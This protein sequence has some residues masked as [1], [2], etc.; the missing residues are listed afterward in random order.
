LIKN[1]DSIYRT[2]KTGI[3]TVLYN[4][5]FAGIIPTI[6]LLNIYFYKLF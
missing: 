2:Y 1:T 5:A 6:I 3:T 4:R